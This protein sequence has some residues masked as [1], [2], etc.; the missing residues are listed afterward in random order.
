MKILQNGVLRVMIRL[1]K[2][3]SSPIAESTI[4]NETSFTAMADVIFHYNNL[5]AFREKQKDL[6]DNARKN[7]QEYRWKT[8]LLYEQMIE[9]V[10]DAGVG[11]I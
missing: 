7:L 9:D 4:L 2:I 5:V 11:R 1:K 6:Q 3:H 10:I 8:P